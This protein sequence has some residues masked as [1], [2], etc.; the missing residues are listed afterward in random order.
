MGYNNR[1]DPV[2]SLVAGDG[3]A[4]KSKPSIT[5]PTVG[6]AELSNNTYSASAMEQSS[7]WMRV[8][9]KVK[10]RGK[11]TVDTVHSTLSLYK[12]KAL[13]LKSVFSNELQSAKPQLRSLSKAKCHKY[14]PAQPRGEH[15][16][17]RAAANRERHRSLPPERR[18]TANREQHRSL[19]PK[20]R[21]TANRERHRSLPPERR[22]TADRKRHRSLPPAPQASNVRRLTAGPPLGSGGDKQKI[23][24]AIRA[25]SSPGCSLEVGT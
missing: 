17:R 11:M 10:V 25:E 4:V 22:A 16:K 14:L 5:P 2:F 15:A 8:R 24:L 23:D 19:P 13:K 12:S 20:G 1:F 3:S 21:A 7:R 6:A 18:A 9:D